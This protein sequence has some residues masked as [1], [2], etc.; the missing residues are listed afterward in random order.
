MKLPE[1]P[2]TDATGD[3]AVTMCQLAFEKRKWK[4]RRQE[5]RSDFGIDAEI[6]IVEKNLVTGQLL[7]GQVK[8]QGETHWE[9]NGYVLVPVAVSTYN[10]WKSLPLPI[11]AL[12]IPTLALR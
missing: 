10:L 8:G 12:P 2:D 3:L 1:T 4:F 5:G 7:K 11:I 6:E 9:M